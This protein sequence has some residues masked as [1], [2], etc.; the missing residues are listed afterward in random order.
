MSAGN[1]RGNSRNSGV[2]KL[3]Y[4]RVVDVITDAFHPEYDTYGKSLGLYGV[5]YS[6]VTTGTSEGEDSPLKF[7]YCANASIRRLPLKNEFV[8]IE[9]RP[10]AEGRDGDAATSRLFWTEIHSIWNHPHHNAYPDTLQV[11]EG[12]ADLGDDFKEQEKIKEK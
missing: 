6:E 3:L 1:R 9:G 5:F 4:G 7:A 2:P 10:D 8:K 12:T 11:G